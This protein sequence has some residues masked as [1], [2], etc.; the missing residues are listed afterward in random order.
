MNQQKHQPSPT[1]LINEHKQQQYL[2]FIKKYATLTKHNEF[3]VDNLETPKLNVQ[4]NQRR[5]TGV[6]NA[7]LLFMD[8]Q[9]PLI[10]PILKATVS[11][12]SYDLNVQFDRDPGK[13]VAKSKVIAN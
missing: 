8:S 10:P 5:F 7:I 6:M 1:R 3:V 4:R 12:L 9:M 13:F 11:G 2:Q